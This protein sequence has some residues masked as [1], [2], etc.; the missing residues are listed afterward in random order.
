MVMRKARLP[1]NIGAHGP[2]ANLRRRG[3]GILQ[4]SLRASLRALPT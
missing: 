3:R 1:A 2:T 4:P